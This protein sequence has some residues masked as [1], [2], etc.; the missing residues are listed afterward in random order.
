MGRKPGNR[1]KALNKGLPTYLGT[2]CSECGLR[3]KR[4]K[5]KHCVPCLELNDGETRTQAMRTRA[6]YRRARADYERN[7]RRARVQAHGT[8]L[9]LYLKAFEPITT[10]T[11]RK[12]MTMVAA[13]PNKTNAK[14]AGRKTYE[15]PYECD[16]CQTTRRYTHSGNCVECAKVAA[17]D[18]RKTESAQ[19]A[20]RDRQARY[21]A[22]QAEKKNALLDD[23]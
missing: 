18:Y 20:N 13:C 2:P 11:T 4:T 15:A 10:T 6:S 3:L 12:E 14:K 23:I 8:T 7:R 22:R 19:Q 5:D 17:K 1:A 9:A 16:A 21:R